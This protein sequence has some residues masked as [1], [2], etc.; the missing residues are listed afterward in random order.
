MKAE[1]QPAYQRWCERSRF[2]SRGRATLAR[3]GNVG[4]ADARR[5]SGARSSQLGSRNG[6]RLYFLACP[7]MFPGPKGIA[8]MRSGL[9]PL[10]IIG[11][12][13]LARSAGAGPDEEPPKEAR[14][15]YQFTVSSKTYAELFRRALLP[16]PDGALVETN[17][18]VPVHE[19]LLLKVRDLDTG[20]GEDSLDIEL[21]AWSQ[22][23]FTDPELERRGDGDVQV[24][25]VRYRDE[26]LSARVGRQLV[27]GGAARYSRFDGLAVGVTPGAGF[28]AGAY[29]GFTVLP[30]FDERPGYHH[31]GAATDSLLRNPDAFPEPERSGNWLAGGRFGF[32]SGPG[33]AALSFHEQHE[34][35]GLSRRS[36]GLDGRLQALTDVS[37]GGNALLELDARRLQDAR[38]W[39]DTTPIPQADLS[40]EYLHAEP[41]LFLSR[42]SVLSVFSTD[43]YDEAGA[44][45][46]L[47]PAKRLALEADGSVQFY[48]ADQRGARTE[49]AAR[50][51]PGTGR[52]TVVRLAYARVLVIDN[53]YHSLRASLSRKLTPE[54][55]G[56]LEA[57]S[58]L[59][60]ER[61]RERKTSEV[62]SGTLG[63]RAAEWASV[64]WGASLAQSPYAQ[65][66]LQTLVRLELDF[67][68]GT[69]SVRP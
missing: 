43:A 64:L 13:L 32:T 38:I 53:A 25:N 31:L 51:E 40:L 66:D 30:R 36:V 10:L 68:L 21:A 4:E 28:D 46:I 55:T 9:I 59:Y 61:I 49:I 7:A 17:T 62:Y 15:R 8:R 39:V 45:A 56:T 2:Q 18:L 34:T 5:G 42:Q 67:D 52:R 44:S 69:R 50:L 65:F 12:S 3:A 1:E 29:A 57:Y 63:Y 16:G 22:F 26:L 41:A 48:D 11:I 27:V 6:R 54:L 33:T 23:S 58:Y 20:L 24:A 60:D 19:Y 47:R 14:D 35:A 37:L